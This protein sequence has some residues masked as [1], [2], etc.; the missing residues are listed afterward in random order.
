MSLFAHLA[1]RFGS[2]P[3]NLATEGLGYIL[4]ASSR[5][6]VGFLASLGN[7]A[8]EALPADLKFA[9]QVSTDDAGRPDLAGV[10]DTGRSRLL[11]EAK[12][13]AG[14]TE[15]Q[16]LSYLDQL[17]VGDVLLVVGPR[18]RL[19]YLH[20]ELARRIVNA[21]RLLDRR[22]DGTELI[23][24]VVDGRHLVL[25][26]WQRV[27]EAMD[28]ELVGEPARADVAQLLGLCNKMDDE[29]YIPITSAELTSNIYR[30]VHEFGAI[31]DDVVAQLSSGPERVLDTKGLRSAASNGRYGR[32][33]LLRGV[34]ALLHVSTHKWTKFA[35][36]PVWLTVYGREWK[37]SDP[38]PVKK[39]LST[40]VAKELGTVDVDYRGFP[41]VPVHVRP[42]AE[43]HELI[44]EMAAQL[45]QIGDVI[46]PFGGA[47]SNAPPPD[48]VSERE[49]S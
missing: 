4:S 22:V 20:R 41:T 16:P 46:A 43:R 23:S 15:H 45:R 18:A 39:A 2:H 47:P 21:K 24:A 8:R 40:M 5:A 33:A 38:E 49:G 10:D 14:F 30:R 13:W 48:E 28:R 26:S 7:D 36:N 29:A 42:G 17:A 32:Y 12:F 27:L 34:P 11:V 35:P 31:V 19:P 37:K 6:R 25:T 9:T 1:V 44:A 3:E